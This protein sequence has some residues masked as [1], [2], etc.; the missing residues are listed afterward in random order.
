MTR[1]RLVIRG[2]THVMMLK[3]EC[4]DPRES[5]QSELVATLRAATKLGG[6]VELA[7]QASLRNDSKVIAD[8]R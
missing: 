7:P 2:E 4:A 1:L 5:L 6:R 8:E 3:A